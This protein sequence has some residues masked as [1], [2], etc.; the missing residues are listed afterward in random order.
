MLKRLRRKI[1]LINMTLVSIVLLLAMTL[2]CYFEVKHARENV[3]RG[4]EHV[5]REL[6]LDDDSRRTHQKLNGVSLPVEPHVAVLLEDHNSWTYLG[7]EG[8]AVSSDVLEKAIGRARA[9]QEQQG[10]LYPYRLIYYRHNAP[11]GTILV[12]G[13]PVSIVSTFFHT[14]LLCINILIGGIAVFFFISLW[15]SHIAVTPISHVWNQQKQFI[16]DASHELKTPL[17]VILANVHIM[18]SH[19]SETVAQQAQWLTA[20][21]EEAEQMQ[22]LLDNMLALAKTDNEQTIIT[23]Q[24]TNGSELI[25]ETLLFLEPV[26]YEKNIP[27]QTALTKNLIWKTDPTLLRRLVSLLVDNALKYSTPGK[28]VTVRLTAGKTIRFSVHNYGSPIPPEALP[29]LFERFF[30]SD[31]SRSTEGHGLGLAIARATAER[32]RGKISVTS[33][34]EDGTTFFVDFKP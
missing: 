28:P 32:L 22:K 2:V 23:L 7:R 14:F 3:C 11:I 16:A 24:P 9:E 17:T 26:A 13:S 4:L 20:T 19:G 33:T 21:Q 6:A 1:I 8:L 10:V 27:L 15:L 25:E 31:K 18:A 34:E 12:F 29:H 30:R 5:A